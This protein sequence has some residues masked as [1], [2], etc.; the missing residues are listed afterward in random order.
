M[1]YETHL[2]FQAQLSLFLK[3]LAQAM[4]ALS[5][6]YLQDIHIYKTMVMSDPGKE[7]TRP[8]PGRHLPVVFKRKQLI[9][10]A[11]TGEKDCI[12]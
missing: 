10:D 4:Q 5:L 3:T 7:K 9:M 11:G 8:K 1:S 6:H 12:K 2:R